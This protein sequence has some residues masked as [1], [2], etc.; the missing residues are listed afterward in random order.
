MRYRQNG[1]EQ[2]LEAD[3]VVGC[4]GAGS[5][6][7]EA[8]GFP[9]EGFTYSIRPI[10][11]DVRIGDGRDELEWPR[12]WNGRDGP[13]V[14]IRL[15]DGLWRII[16][17][18]RGDPTK[19]DDVPEEEI[20]D[21]VAETLGDGPFAIEWANRFRI[22][23]RSAPRFRSGRVLL[24]GDAAHVHSPVGGLGMNAGI[25]DAHN[26][27]WKLATALQRGDVDRLLDSYDVERR[28]VVVEDVS[29]YTD[30]LTRLFLQVP[31]TVRAAAFLFLRLWLSFSGP[32]KLMIR[33][34]TMIG[35]GYEESP[36]LVRQDRAAGVRLPNP[37]LRCPEG[38]RTRL[39]DLL[40]NAPVVL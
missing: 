18:E 20:G 38:N 8:L 32:R 15:K 30:V 24:A 23:L 19:D 3:F 13:S 35:L 17:L 40:P 22:H 27:A 11:A 26:L 21:R 6:V 31:S 12:V 28:A 36:L 37:I 9:F 4:D 7:R 5:F 14:A 1:S 34:A 39:Y 10:L 29:T 25:Q 33:R 16:R 2:A